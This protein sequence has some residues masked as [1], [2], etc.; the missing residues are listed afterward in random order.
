MLRSGVL[1]FV[2]AM[3]CAFAQTDGTIAGEVRDAT[4]APIALAKIVVQSQDRGTSVEAKSGDNGEYIILGLQ[5]GEYIVYAEFAGFQKA[6]SKVHVTTDGRAKLDFVLVPNE[7]KQTVEVNADPPAL[8]TE[9]GALTT[10][11]TER[12]MQIFPLQGRGSLEL[13][14]LVP[15]VM[16]EAGSDEAG[17][18]QDVPSAGAGLSVGGGRVGSTAILADGAGSNSVGIGRATV[19]FSTDTIQEFQVITSTFSAKY[20]VSGGG[21][22]NSVSKSGTNQLRGSAYWYHRNPSVNARQFNRPFP[23]N[24]RRQEF[25]LTIGGPVYIPKLYN[26]RRKTF[27]FASLEPKRY[28]DQIDIYS[29]FPTAAERTGDFRNSYVAPGQRRPMLYQQYR[30]VPAPQNCN[31]LT[32]LN[33]PNATAEYPLFGAGDPD[34]TK[35]GLVIPAYMIDPLAKKLLADVPLPNM[36]FDP[37]GRNYFGTRGVD[38]T[39]GRWNAKVDH[40]F[41]SRNRLSGR[42]SGVPLFSDRY[43]VAK[44]NVFMSYPSDISD[45]KQLMITDTHNFSPTILND[46]RAIYTFGDYSRRPPGEMATTNYTKDVF[47]LPNVTNFGYPFFQTGFGNYGLDPG[48][49]LGTY[50]EHQYVDCPMPAAATTCGRPRKPI[51]ATTTHWAAPADYSSLRF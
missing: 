15:G 20:G 38:G 37:Q 32:Q 7:S 19:T 12:E 21:V 29:R 9:S 34:P 41:S 16:G 36:P 17:I 25:G 49:G 14:L 4:Q 35:R 40:H 2:L 45:T 46:L 10:T 5:P 8:D 13:A 24:N 11:F 18:F 1:T 39:D 22:I 33:R 31:Q 28:F 3:G 50:R 30:C 23:N 26:G 51:P 43:R 47:G 6:K 27:F 44:G 42:Y 48:A